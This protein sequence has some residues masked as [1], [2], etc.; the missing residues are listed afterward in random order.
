M[1]YE[2]LAAAAVIASLCRLAFRLAILVLAYRLFMKVTE[3][4]SRA[5]VCDLVRSF[6]GRS[7]KLRSPNAIRRTSRRAPRR[8]PNR[9][10]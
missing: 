10:N 3:P 5:L 4:E 8:T 6:E 2:E 7:L 1:R 9:R